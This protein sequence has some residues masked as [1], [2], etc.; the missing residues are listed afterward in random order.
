MKSL[1]VAAA[2]A[3]LAFMAAATFLSPDA[4]V[5]VRGRSLSHSIQANPAAFVVSDLDPHSPGLW[6]VG[7]ND[8]GQ[9]V[10]TL[11]RV[12]HA[13][14]FSRRRVIDLGR[15]AGYR[16][17][18]AVGVSAGG[19]VLA[20]A[21]NKNPYGRTAFVVRFSSGKHQW[22]R[23]GSGIPGF[24]VK[25]AAQIDAQGDVIG[26]LRAVNG[27]TN[28]DRAALWSARTGFRSARRL[29]LPPSA[30]A[31]RAQAVYRGSAFLLI[32]AWLTYPRNGSALPGTIIWLLRRGRIHLS[33]PE[34]NGNLGMF[35]GRR[36]R[37]YAAGSDGGYDYSYGWAAPVVIRGNTVNVN[38]AAPFAAPPP[39][40][41]MF[42]NVSGVTADGKGRMVAIGDNGANADSGVIWLPHRKPA[43]LVNLIGPKKHWVLNTPVAINHRGEIV[44]RGWFGGRSHVYLLTPSAGLLP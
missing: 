35:G 16:Y 41:S 1:A 43:L 20:N 30:T 42:S 15:P 7:I 27:P 22:V 10:G 34:V 38:E 6:P 25:S 8:A 4:M 11:T 44:G 24:V 23:L 2:L 37:I 5:A 21:Y 19:T 12:Q 18:E 13:F 26:T 9:V 14:I 28:G 3:A 33:V 40:H 32:S 39:G 29:P 36:R 17:S 31:A